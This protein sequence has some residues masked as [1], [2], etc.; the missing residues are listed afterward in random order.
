M[1][2][3]FALPP[4]RLEQLRALIAQTPA[5]ER[6][7]LVVRWARPMAHRFRLLPRFQSTGQRRW[8]AA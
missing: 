7:V 8:R 3:W 2:R 6:R 5:H 1:S 4:S